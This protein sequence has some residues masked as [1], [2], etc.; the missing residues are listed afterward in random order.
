MK[1]LVTGASG[2]I[3]SHLKNKLR[4]EGHE[5]YGMSRRPGQEFQADIR[6]TA[7]VVDFVRR[8]G[9][10]VVFHLSAALGSHP[11]G[12]EYI[13]DVNYRATRALAEAL[14][15]EPVK[16]VFFSSTGV[17]GNVPPGRPADE[18]SPL[19]PMS[20]YERSKALAEEAVMKARG[21]GLR[22]WIIRP[23][24]VYGPGDRRTFKLF[25]FL[26]KNTPL[27]GNGR[28]HQHPIYIR[29]LVEASLKFLGEP[30]SPIYIIS[31]DE[32]LTVRELVR[33]ACASFG[34]RQERVFFPVTPVL[35]AS[36]PLR[37]FF[38]LMGR[39][40]PITPAKVSFFT[41]NREFSVERARREL[42]FSPAVDFARG[43]ARAFEW[44]KR[45]GWL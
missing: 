2:F 41:V 22:A 21:R 38:S 10:Q 37:W 44:Y 28:N 43:T 33:V 27:P 14:I 8:E 4:E 39:E 34:C 6:D 19:S 42:G 29:D 30:P 18:D 32:I 23:G 20:P 13:M 31:G 40:A 1:I 12:E 26:M 16:F 15:P 9:I 24:W 11:G 3:G 17:H 35:V 5:V 25:K 36:Y 45:A 7:K